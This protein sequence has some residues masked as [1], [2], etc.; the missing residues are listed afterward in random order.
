M[1]NLHIDA[2]YTVLTI[3][4][5]A[6]AKTPQMKRQVKIVAVFCVLATGIV[7]IANMNMPALRGFLR[8]RTSDA[9][10]KT[11]GPNAKPSTYKA[12]A[13][14]ET[15]LDIPNSVDKTWFAGLRIDDANVARKVSIARLPVMYTFLVV[16]KFLGL[17]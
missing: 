10:P 3:A 11:V 13:R 16:E 17:R 12:V 4:S 14:I 15:S 6:D 8:P 1:N 7:K 5:G 9:G 2:N